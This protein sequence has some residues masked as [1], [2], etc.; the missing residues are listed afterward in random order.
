MSFV[1][2]FLYRVPILE[3]P[4][5]EVPLYCVTS[6]NILLKGYSHLDSWA[7]SVVGLHTND[8]FMVALHVDLSQQTS[9]VGLKNDYKKPYMHTH[10]HCL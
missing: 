10:M 4:L 3:S 2:R 9:T 1:E 5:S 6:D 7:H 8:V